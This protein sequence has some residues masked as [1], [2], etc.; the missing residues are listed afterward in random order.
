MLIYGAMNRESLGTPFDT[1]A[2]KIGQT[3]HY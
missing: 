1:I 3:T 2:I